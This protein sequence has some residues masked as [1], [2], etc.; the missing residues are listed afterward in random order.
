MNN[1][2]PKN[3]GDQEK[4]KD[5]VFKFL[6]YV[7]LPIALGII[8]ILALCLIFPEYAFMI[9]LMTGLM[10]LILMALGNPYV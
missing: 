10:A 9:L 6:K 2:K 8:G 7:V 1:E 4:L 3:K 5:S